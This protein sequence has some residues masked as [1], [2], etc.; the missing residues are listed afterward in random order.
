MKKLVL[1]LALLFHIPLVGVSSAS[2]YTITKDESRRDVKRSVEVSL[3]GKISEEKLR[4]I[5]QEIY[6]SS[7]K[8]YERTFIGYSIHELGLDQQAWATTHFNPNLE[9]KILG[10]TLE[11]E[12]LM[13]EETKSVEG[14]KAIGIWIDERIG[15][16]LTIFEKNGISYLR[17]EY[18]DGSSGEQE[19]VSEEA[20]GGR[21]YAT[22]DNGFGE[23]FVL[24]EDGRLEFWGG[25]GNYY[26]ADPLR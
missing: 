3:P 26:T 15:G 23:Y 8:R 9:V 2:E 5:A 21:K 24:S 19:L 7:S 16:K 1:V 18:S 13:R 12:R 22:P 4:S 10:L 11:Q 25:S 20:S 17:S 14:E 6:A